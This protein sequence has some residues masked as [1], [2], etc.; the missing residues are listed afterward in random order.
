MHNM[1]IIIRIQRRRRRVAPRRL[2]LSLTPQPLC[3]RPPLRSR[4]KA[5]LLPPFL[6]LPTLKKESAEDAVAGRR[7]GQRRQRCGQNNVKE[8]V[9]LAVE[10]AEE[11]RKARDAQLILVRLSLLLINRSSAAVRRLCFANSVRLCDDINNKSGEVW[12]QDSHSGHELSRVR[13]GHDQLH[14]P[15]VPT[16]LHIK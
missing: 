3:R 11:A 12:A 14:R 4:P 15:L 8:V 6:L 7:V 10:R 2:P 9:E 13:V 5:P 1:G 16:R